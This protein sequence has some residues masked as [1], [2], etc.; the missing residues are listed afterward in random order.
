MGSYALTMD[1]I[2]KSFVAIETAIDAGITRFDHANIYKFGKSE[3]VFGYYLS[4]HKNLRDSIEIQSKVGI[5]IP[6][7]GGNN[8][9]DYR[10]DHVVGEV[11]K[12]LHRLQTEYLDVL[13]LHRPD[14]LIDRKEFKR[15]IDHLFDSGKVRRLGVSN[16]STSHI[17]LLAQYSE[18]KIVANQ[19]EMGLHKRDWV[20]SGLLFNHIDHKELSVEQGTVEFCM[21]NDIE[22]Q[23]WSPLAQGIYSGRSLE[24]ADSAT[25]NTARLVEKLAKEKLVSKEAIVLAWLMRHPANIVPV[26]GSSNPDRIRLCTQARDVVMTHREWYELMICA[27]G[28]Q[29]P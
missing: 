15:T 1:D 25:K 27:R 21:L 23:A 28:V 24:N 3:E 5:N 17:G 11:D 6:F 4:D 10:Y 14:A 29:L 22:L 8:F 12:I 18:R 9:Y 19:L 13:L 7:D 16:M 2:N 20:E 26:I